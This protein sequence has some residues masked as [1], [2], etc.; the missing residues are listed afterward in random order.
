[1]EYMSCRAYAK[2]RGVS[3]MAVSDAIR[4]GRLVKSVVR[5]ENGDPKIADPDLADQEWAAHTDHSKAPAYVKE[6]ESARVVVVAPPAEGATLSEASAAEKVWKAKLAELKYRELAGELV[7]AADVEREVTNYIME[8]KTRLLGLPS[9]ARQL[10][11]ELT[12]GQVAKLEDLV[13]EALESLAR[14]GN[15]D[16]MHEVR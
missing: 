7:E 3:A 10:M 12:I 9:R 13:R 6:R 8:C 16:G 1:M 14:E 5:V 4:Q 15:T 2:R 11:P